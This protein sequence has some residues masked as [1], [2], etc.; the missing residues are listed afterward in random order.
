MLKELAAIVASV[1]T[2]LAAVLTSSE[3][4][5]AGCV[6]GRA[7]VDADAPIIGGL[8]EHSVKV[9]GFATRWRG[10][11]AVDRDLLRLC[12]TT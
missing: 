6:L 11:P 5:N 4:W 2:N 3:R 9:N 1:K 12:C 7:G 8:L 10:R